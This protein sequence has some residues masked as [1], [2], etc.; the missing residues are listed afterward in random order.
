[1]QNTS[2]A[3]TA[4]RKPSLLRTTIT[5]AVFVSTLALSLSTHANM[6]TDWNARLGQAIKTSVQG[7]IPQLRVAAIFHAAVFDAVN[8]I[9]GDY[10]PYFVSERA[11]GGA[12]QEA[13]I[14]QAAYTALVAMYPPQKT[15]FDA[16]LSESL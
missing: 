4:G 15:N 5:L 7:P 16:E 9:A 12:R 13:A 8:A 1:M 6:V 3:M 10:E 14:A 11:P 2:A